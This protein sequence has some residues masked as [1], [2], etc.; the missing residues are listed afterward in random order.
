M[1]WRKKAVRTRV[2]FLRNPLE[3]FT[4]PP[5]LWRAGGVDTSWLLIPLAGFHWHQEKLCGAAIIM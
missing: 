2:N 4:N 5:I 3:I 1:T